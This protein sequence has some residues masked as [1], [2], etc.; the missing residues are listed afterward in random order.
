MRLSKY[1]VRIEE[2]KFI[3]IKFRICLQQKPTT[4][5]QISQ[6]F[7]KLASNFPKITSPLLEVFYNYEY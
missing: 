1:G 4:T 7:S 6:E 3:V 5:S 2:A